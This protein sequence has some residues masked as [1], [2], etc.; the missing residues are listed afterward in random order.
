M[1]RKFDTSSNNTNSNR[2][3]CVMRRLKRDTLARKGDGGPTEV[4]CMKDG[5]ELREERRT[6]IKVQK[7]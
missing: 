7:T 5:K 3:C 1:F 6:Q 2:Q 4:R